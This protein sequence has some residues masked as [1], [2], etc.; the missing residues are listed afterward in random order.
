MAI[1]FD[2]NLCDQNPYCP[3]TRIC[4]TGAMYVDRTTYMPTFDPEKCSG[5]GVCVSSCPRNAVTEK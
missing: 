4:P 1:E 5:C 2:K 3:V